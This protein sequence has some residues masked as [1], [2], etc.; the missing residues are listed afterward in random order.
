MTRTDASTLRNV[1]S[2]PQTAFGG[3]CAV[4]DSVI[5]EI[6]AHAGFDWCC[7]DLQHGAGAQDALVPMLQGIEDRKSV[8]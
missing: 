6:M 4:L 5:A 1:L 3:W 8:V 7:V 2:T